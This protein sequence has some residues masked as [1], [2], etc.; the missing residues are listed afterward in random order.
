MENNNTHLPEI[1]RAM[2]LKK[3]RTDI[4]SLPPEKALDRILDHS[5]PAA[6]VHSFPEEDFYFLVHD[7]GAEDALP[8]LSLA[9]NRQLDFILDQEIW[10]KDR[11]L[12]AS[13]ARWLG[14]MLTAGSR[15]F[16][17]WVKENKTNLL[18]FFLYHNIEVKIRE[19]DQDA[20]EFGEDF[21]TFDDYYY[22][23][24]LP[25]LSTPEADS[26]DDTATDVADE[27]RRTLVRTLLQG[28][29][30]I[31]HKSY[32]NILLESASLLPAESE[33]AAY[34]WR[35]VRLAEKGFL[36]F[37][38]A[39]GIYQ[40]LKPE[41]L[42]KAAATIGKSRF[43]GDPH[44][45]M[46]L[47]PLRMIEKGSFFSDALT[48]ISLD[49]RFNE[50]QG[51]FASLCNQII[52]ADQKIIKSREDLEAAVKKA[53]GYINIA[54]DRMGEEMQ[55]PTSAGELILTHPLSNLFRA[56]YGSALSLK[57]QAQNLVKNSWFASKKLNLTFWGEEWMGVLGG[58]LIKKPLF[59]DNYETGVLY[60]EFQ[61]ADDIR[62]TETVLN[63]I[64]ACDNLLSR[65]S[66]DF[67]E[68]SEPGYLSYKNVLLTLWA[69]HT[70]GLQEGINPLTLEELKEFYPKLWASKIKPKKISPSMKTAFV[71]FLAARCG[72][73]SDD[74]I[75]QGGPFFENLFNGL[76]N[77]YAE[78]ET[79][80]LDPRFTPLFL[81]KQDL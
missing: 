51:E 69:R 16:L 7:I 33:E 12:N 65:A 32:Q 58:L 70:L 48:E 63:H 74:L 80:A 29:A 79:E 45:P 3:E 56:G 35:N 55:T 27:F 25:N 44:L 14:L 49:D 13:L 34:R 21:E 24:I 20:S 68:S 30:G 19:H 28:L 40:P 2:A 9:S 17:S 71:N 57:W 76:E 22:F 50:I 67:D 62:N 11:I 75:I 8:L 31:D 72:L 26:G 53:C 64:I 4:L 23:R 36:T 60:R 39:I 37:D 78:I 66:I 61:S 38:E 81:M 59:F 46:P 5:Q 47:T 42:L 15:R 6:L 1:N 18:E 52:V 54:L 10:A 73:E 43:S 41:D 77:E